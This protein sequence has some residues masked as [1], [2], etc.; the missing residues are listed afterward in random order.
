MAEDGKFAA[1]NLAMSE[2][3]KAF[4]QRPSGYPTEL[5]IMTFNDEPEVISPAAG[6]T[7]ELAWRPLEPH[8]ATALGAALRVARDLVAAMP[9]SRRLAAVLVSD[10][11]PTDEWREPLARLSELEQWQNASRAAIAIGADADQVSLAA[12]SGSVEGVRLVEHSGDVGRLIGI[13]LN[14]DVPSVV[15]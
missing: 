4:V 5:R 10:G 9:Q 11:S 2:L 6:G 12:F 15:R 7:T 1:L 14:V 3:L 8:G 13:M